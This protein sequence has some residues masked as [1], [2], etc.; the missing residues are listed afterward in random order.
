MKRI[1]F[2]ELSHI[3]TNQ[4]KLPYSSGCV[5]SYCRT[6]AEITKLYQSGAG[7]QLETGLPVWKEKGVA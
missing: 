2:L 5:W 4:V 7:F 6:D 3:F 1:A